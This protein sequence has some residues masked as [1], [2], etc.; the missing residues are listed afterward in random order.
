MNGGV[1]DADNSLTISGTVT[2]AGN[3]TIDVASGKTLTFDNG[4][5][6]TE[7]YQLTIE[8]AG[9]IAFPANASGIVVNNAAGLLKLNGTGTLQAARVTADSN[10]GKGVQVVK[11]STISNLEVLADAKLNIVSGETLSGSTEVAANKTLSLS[12]TGT[13]GSA[14]NLKGTLEAGANL[15]VSGAIS[16]ADNATVSIPAAGTTLSYSGGNLTVGAYTFSIGGS[17]TFGN[18]AD[19]PIVLAVEDSVLDLTGNGII[20]GPFRL[21]GGTLKASGSPTISGDL[22]QYDNATIEVASGQTLTYSGTSLNLGANE[23][24][25]SGGGTFNN[26]N[27]LVLNNADSLLALEGIVTIGGVNA[28]D[29]ASS[30]KM[31]WGSATR[32]T[33]SSQ[34]FRALYTQLNAPAAAA[35]A[36]PAPINERR[37]IFGSIVKDIGLSPVIRNHNDLCNH[38]MGWLFQHKQNRTCNVFSLKALPMVVIELVA[39]LGTE[40]ARC[41]KIGFHHA[42]QHF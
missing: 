11:S 3:A 27:A 28:T 10:A 30:G 34:L 6:N 14:L 23:L 29:N 39:T 20:S 19:S 9:T 31:P 18:A 41:C 33:A 25:L 22:T 4:T 16:V 36:T 1:L 12:G 32:P 21:E 26:S 35:A 40:K 42:R 2:Q 13:L 8:G 5:I 38:C 7:N 24:T 37:E 15:T 17:G